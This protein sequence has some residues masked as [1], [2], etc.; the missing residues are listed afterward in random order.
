MK[1]ETLK[2]KLEIEEKI[3][4]EVS[5]IEVTVKEKIKQLEADELRLFHSYN[6][7]AVSKVKLEVLTKLEEVIHQLEVLKKLN[8]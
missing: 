7:H 3:I 8:S 2:Q 1:S 6:R 4:I 5:K